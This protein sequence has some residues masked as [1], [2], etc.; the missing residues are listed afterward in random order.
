VATLR[1]R[2]VRLSRATVN[3]TIAKARAEKKILNLVG[4]DL[5]ASDWSGVDFTCTQY[6]GLFNSQVLGADFRNAKLVGSNFY[7]VDLASANL[8]GTDLTDAVLA[9][10][11]LYTALLGSA[12]LVR[13]NLRAAN[14]VSAEL[15]DVEL[16]ETQFAGARFGRTAISGVDLSRAA[17]LNEAVH[18]YPSPVDSGTLERT[19]AG[20]RTVGDVRRSEVLRFLSN[21]GFS[22]DFLAL[23]RASIGKPIEFYSVFLSHSSLDK[24]FARRLYSDLRTM[25]VACWFDE[26]QILPGSGILEEIDRGVK[27]WD[28]LIL[29]CSS[30][31]LSAKTGWWVEQELERALRKERELRASEESRSF[32]VIP[33]AIDNYVFEKWESPFR[34]TILERHV[35]DFRSWEDPQEYTRALERLVAAVGRRSPG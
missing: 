18:V 11:N 10:S 26:H 3:R 31:S 35:G 21:T 9:G 14:L 5:A 32:A 17:E 29:V 34:A 25:G 6:D 4:A 33:I 28:K 22:E 23:F 2:R 30:N 24:D 12:T 15:N 13:S 7:R 8:R 20:L 19:A 27:M 1:K 16:D